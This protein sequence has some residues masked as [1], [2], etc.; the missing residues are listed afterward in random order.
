MDPKDFENEEKAGIELQ[1]G[2]HAYFVP[3]EHKTDSREHFMD[4]SRPATVEGMVA[5]LNET[6]AQIEEQ[7]GEVINVLPLSQDKGNAI[8]SRVG[9]YS[10]IF[11]VK[12]Q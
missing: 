11:I 4:D 3:Q 9:V 10:W 12:K 2:T 8:V 6:L 7:G 5:T 1:T